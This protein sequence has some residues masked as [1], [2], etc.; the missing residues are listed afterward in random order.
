MTFIKKHRKFIG[1]LTMHMVIITSL[2]YLFAAYTNIP[3]LVKA[4]ALYIETALQTMSHKWLA[5]IFP[6]D[7][8]QEV[9]VNAEKQIEENKVEKSEPVTKAEPVEIIQI[10]PEDLPQNFT[11]VELN[12]TIA[13]FELFPELDPDT[14][15]E[16]FLHENLE[17][18][19]LEGDAIPSSVRTRQGD[20][21]Y[22]IDMPNQLLIVNVSGDGYAGK[23]AIVKNAGRVVLAKNT[24]SG[25]GST[26]TE[27]VEENGAVLGVNASGFHDAGGHG[28]GDVPVGLVLSQGEIS[29]NAIGG[30]Y[31]MGG[32]DYNDNFYVG[33]SLDLSEMRDAMEFFPNIVLN[34]ENSTNGSYG[35]GI[36]PRTAIGQTKSGDVLL[37]VIDGRQAHSIGITVSELAD[38]MLRY[39]C[40][41]ALN[42]DGGSSSSMTYNDQMITK[43]SSPQKG[44]RWLPDAWLVMPVPDEPEPDNSQFEDENIRLPYDPAVILK[45]EAKKTEIP[46]NTKPTEQTPHNESEPE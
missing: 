42:V 9:Q 31:Q 25:R 35:M 27:F 24:R 41:V 15:P 8:V 40:W 22:A 39:D 23:M 1:V 21:V 32:F 2:I 28:S 18:L 34:G 26:V 44:G 36:Q 14:F 16:D 20:S 11:E 38:V 43:T 10:T 7:I 45:P 33:T 37:L 3:S 17:N 30:S 12:Q 13:L 4:R 29:N 46:D 5:D 19:Q 6:K